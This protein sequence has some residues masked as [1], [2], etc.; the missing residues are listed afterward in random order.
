MASSDVLDMRVAVTEAVA[1]VNRRPGQVSVRLRFDSG[2]P[3][4]LVAN[5]ATLKG[6]A[7]EF[8]AGYETYAGNIEE[9][10]DIEVTR[11]NA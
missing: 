2:D 3:L 4:D 8:V 11:I 1:Q 7:F 6:S 5:A 9:L 10:V